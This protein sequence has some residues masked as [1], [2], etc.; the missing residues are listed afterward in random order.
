M[1][2]LTLAGLLVVVAVTLAINEVELGIIEVVDTFFALD[3]VVFSAPVVE[4]VVLDVVLNL[5]VVVV[6]D[7]VGLGVVVVVEVVVEVVVDVVLVVVVVVVVV[8]G[9]S[10]VV[11]VGF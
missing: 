6:V 10:V 8:F 11:V 2:I 9:F 3:F 1:L 7:V 5:V 4:T